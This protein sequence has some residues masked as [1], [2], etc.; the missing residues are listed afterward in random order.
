MTGCFNFSQGIR[1]WFAEDPSR[2][3]S[4]LN[5]HWINESI[6]IFMS[7]DVTGKKDRRLIMWEDAVLSP[8]SAASNVPKD[9]IL[10]SW[11]AGIDHINQITELGYDVIVASADFLYL[12]CGDGG[13]VTND[14]RY[15]DQFNPDPDVPN[16]NYLGPGGSWCAPFKTWQRIY[17][18][19]FT[20]NLTEAQKKHVIGAS[21]QM[22][23]EQ[24][25]DA[26]ISN[27][28]W[29]R[30][31]ALG[32]LVWSGNKDPKTGK[33][34]TTLLTQRILNFREYLLANGISASPVVPKYC[35]Q[36]PHHCDF[37]YDQEAVE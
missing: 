10:Q 8:N 36:H 30:A 14:P 4:N 18:Y 3:Y 27:K 13:H 22:W 17:D 31:A 19:D 28:L 29:P 15:N 7:E 25:D 16:F 20:T 34:R 11:N 21:A 12:D 23:A 1:D 32:E 2:T 26:T 35:L 37:F 33:K 5:E 24:N 9:V 6:P